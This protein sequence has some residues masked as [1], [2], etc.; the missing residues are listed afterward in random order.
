MIDRAKLGI[1]AF[2]QGYNC[3][4]SVLVAFEDI[5]S[6]NK[7]QLLSIG[8]S[9]GGGFARTRN[10]CGAVNAMGIIYGLVKK[11]DKAVAYKDMQEPI[12]EF[13]SV[14][15]SINCKDIL[16]GVEVTKGFV[17]EERTKKYYATRPCEYVVEFCIRTIEK[18]L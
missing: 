2:R 10:L 4:Q 18:Y 16:K 17:P 11:V 13:I 14:F 12:N 3:S 5:V 15:S 7:E 8:A 1:N 9:L 6:L